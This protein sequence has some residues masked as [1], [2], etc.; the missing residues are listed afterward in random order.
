LKDTENKLTPGQR[1]SKCRKAH[2]PKLTQEALAEIIGCTTQT[3]SNI[4]NDRT[5]LEFEK[6][7][8]LA[9]VFGVSPEYL[10]AKTENKHY[11][12]DVELAISKMQRYVEMKEVFLDY[13]AMLNDFDS[14]PLS[15]EEQVLFFADVEWYAKARMMK[16]NQEKGESNGQESK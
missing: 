12:G 7:Y 6:A 10:Q 5:A 11:R 2:V 14:C 13:I 9:A 4:E 16:M 3:I 15:E 1:V 8:K